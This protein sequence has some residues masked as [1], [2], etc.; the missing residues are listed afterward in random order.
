MAVKALVLGVLAVLAVAAVAVAVAPERAWEPRA[1]LLKKWTR[2]L[3][4]TLHTLRCVVRG[5]TSMA[6]AVRAVAVGAVVAVAVSDVFTRFSCTEFPLGVTRAL[7]SSLCEVP[8]A[9]K[10]SA[11]VSSIVY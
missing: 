7:F 4:V 11:R 10:Q 1:A 5:T 6:M 3:V 8:V 2:H 9:R